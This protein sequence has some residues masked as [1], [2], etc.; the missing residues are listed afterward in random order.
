MLF[1]HSAFTRSGVE[2]DVCCVVLRIFWGHAAFK[3]GVFYLLCADQGLTSSARNTTPYHHWVRESSNIHHM[4]KES[5]SV[6][7]VCFCFVFLLETIG[8]CTGTDYIWQFVPVEL[9]IL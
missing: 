6:K 5:K 8:N 7:V 9:E 2:R 3:S 4:I 1:H